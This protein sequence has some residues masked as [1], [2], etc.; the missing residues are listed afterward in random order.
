MIAIDA[1]PPVAVI[2]VGSRPRTSVKSGN[3]RE[4]VG[5]QCLNAGNNID[6]ATSLSF[7]FLIQTTTATQVENITRAVDVLAANL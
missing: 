6:I 4:C 7:H 3:G 5:V 1:A 2:M